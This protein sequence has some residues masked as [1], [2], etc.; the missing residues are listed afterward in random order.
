MNTKLLYVEDDLEYAGLIG[1]LLAN[2][3]FE[4]AFAPTAAKADK[5]FREF[6]P[7]L[8]IVDL[9]LQYEKE[10]L[11]IIRSIHRQSPWFPVIVYSS[12]ADPQTVIETMAYGVL[13]HVSKDRSIPELVAMLRNALRQTYRC[14]EHQNPEY[15][16]S[17]ITTYYLNTKTLV[18][19]GK[20]FP[21]NRMTGTLLQQLCLHINEFVPPEELFV[22]I[23]GFRKEM[24]E[25]R[26][27][28]TKLRKIIEQ[29]PDLRLLNQSGGYYQLE[30]NLWKQET[31]E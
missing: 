25:L 11:E 1:K 29:D 14:K 8:V 24:S 9:D 31:K 16:L 15:R 22:A 2:E 20:T 3:G 13:H 10:G 17:A 27:Y 30:C 23:W 19:D 26:R 6:R 5:L 7:E 18:T 21:L 28:I 4:T 12:H